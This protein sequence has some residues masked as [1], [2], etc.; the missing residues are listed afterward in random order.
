MRRH[1]ALWLSLAVVTSFVGGCARVMDSRGA[2]E[3]QPQ[4]VGASRSLAADW[5]RLAEPGRRTQ[6][7]QTRASLTRVAASTDV[8]GAEPQRSAAGDGGSGP[9]IPASVLWPKEPWEIEL[10]KVVRNICR[11]C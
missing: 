9:K 1:K 3:A 8:P 2:L 6:V 10:D 5:N 7:A 4:A 11:G